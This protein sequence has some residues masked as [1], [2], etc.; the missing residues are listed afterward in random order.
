M[1]RAVTTPRARVRSGRGSRTPDAAAQALPAQLEH[2]QQRFHDDPA[3][4]LGLADAT[5]AERD[6]N[7]ADPGA[8]AGRAVGHLDLE[9]IAAGM[10]TVGGDRP[11]CRRPPCLEATGQV[12]HTEPEHNAREQAAA[13]RDQP[14]PE[15]PVLDPA[16]GRVPR[17]DDQVGLVVDDRRHECRQDRRVVGPVGIHLEHDRGATV[18]GGRKAVQVRTPEALFARPVTHVDAAI[19]GRQLIGD[20]PGSVGRRVIDDEQRRARQH[21]QD[22]V[23][24][25]GQVVGLVVRRQHDPGAFADHGTLGIGGR[26]AGRLEVGHSC[27]E[28]RARVSGPRPS[29]S[30]PSGCPPGRGHRSGSRT[31]PAV[32]AGRGHPGHPR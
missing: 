1:R 30:G 8:G 12:V 26:G 28:C 7:L 31:Y 22:R 3:A 5:L 10:D 11:E 14:P 24:D 13:A 29:S 20:P 15:P 16:T 6:R 19:R 21:R 18:E 4:H 9:H 2:D 25:P 23:G 32:P 17:A 27:E